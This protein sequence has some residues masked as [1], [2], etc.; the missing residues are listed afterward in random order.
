MKTDI[1]TLKD[2][3]K[4]GYYASEDSREEFNTVETMFHNNQFSDKQ[5]HTLAERG[6]PAETFNVIKLFCRQLVGY[7]STVVNTTVIKPRQ[8]E[9][10]PLTSILSDVVSYI[11]ERNNWDSQGDSVKLFGILSGLFCSYIDVQ[12]DGDKKDEFGRQLFNITKEAVH[13]SELVLDPMSIAADY[14]DARFIHRFRWTT[15]EHIRSMFSKYKVDKLDEFENFLNVEDA[16]FNHRFGEQFMG[17]YREFNNYLLV[18]SIVTDDKDESWS[19]YWSGDYILSKT[20]VT[21]KEVKSPYRVVKLQEYQKGWYGLFREVIEPQNAINQAIIQIQ[22]LAN[23]N[24][25]LVRD[26]AVEDLDEFTAAYNRVNSIIPVQDIS[27]IKIEQM[28]GEMQ[29]QYLI[30][31]KAF[32]RIQRMLGINDSFLGMAFASDSGRKV[33][34]QQNATVMALRYIDTKLRLFYRLTSWDTVNL[35]KQYYRAS[36]VLRITDKVSGDRWIQLNKPLI[37]PNTNQPMYEEDMDPATGEPMEDEFGNIIMAPL[38][39]SR[40]DIS[41]LDVDLKIEAVNYNDEDEKNQLMV[42]TV[43][44]GNIGNALMTVNPGGFFKMASLSM[45][46]MKTK[47][48]LEISTILEETS[49]T[50]QPQPQQQENLGGAQL[51][52]QSA[53]SQQL[54]L[55]KNAEEN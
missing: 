53:N 40:T 28:S 13:P 15:E 3:F 9:D 46:D 41:F 1:D 44:S 21:Y 34:L 18:H 50:L 47:N 38:N 45:R 55:P 6:Q 23:T 7:Y 48:S 2:S 52:G 17:D 12:P 20:K 5:L 29:Q 54:K 25:V 4:L 19:I 32:D 39:D 14:S 26:G 27:G 35:V 33:K 43:L 30:I 31:D 24:K 36:Q 51:G 49:Q 42:E 8:L 22:L 10:E 37:D 11:D 16:S